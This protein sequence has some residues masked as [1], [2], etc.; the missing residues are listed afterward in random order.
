MATIGYKSKLVDYIKKNLKKRYTED[1]L[2]WAL[3]SQGYTRSLVEDTIKQAHKELAN[4]F[5]HRNRD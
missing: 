3:V 1:S 4:S 5:I 2:R